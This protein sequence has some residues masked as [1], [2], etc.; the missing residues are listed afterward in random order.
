[1]RRL[2][3]L[4]LLYWPPLRLP[5]L[6]ILYRLFFRSPATGS[7]TENRGESGSKEEDSKPSSHT[8]PSLMT[9]V[10]YEASPWRGFFKRCRA[11]DKRWLL[12]A[13]SA[14][15][16]ARNCLKGGREV[17]VRHSNTHEK[18]AS[19]R[20]LRCRVVLHRSL[21]FPKAPRR[22]RAHALREILNAIFYIV[23]SGSTA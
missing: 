6:L 11:K 10:L 21:S 22:P 5:F 12:P 8:S 16:V 2:W 7:C 17:V 9:D 4:W 20:P 15:S 3:W 13:R 18:E 19:N 1:L 23:S 14:I